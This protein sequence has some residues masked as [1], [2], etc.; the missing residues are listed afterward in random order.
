[1]ALATFDKRNP[2]PSKVETT[3]GV[4]I[5]SDNT[6][7]TGLGMPAEDHFRLFGKVDLSTCAGLVAANTIALIDIPK[8]C[9][10]KD[11]FLNVTTAMTGGTSPTISVGIQGT[12]AGFVALTTLG[13]TGVTKGAGA[14]LSGVQ[15]ANQCVWLAFG[16]TL[17][18][19]GI[20]EVYVDCAKAIDA[21]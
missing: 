15:S 14:L 10:I 5:G 12:T 18:T 4:V 20:V 8:G 3:N 7:A 17:G 21:R 11:V 16:G 9:Q 2:L 19:G 1:M 6:T 13:A